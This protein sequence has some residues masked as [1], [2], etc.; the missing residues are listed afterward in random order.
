MY[1]TFSKCSTLFHLKFP[2]FPTGKSAEFPRRIT[3]VSRLRFHGP[4]FRNVAWQVLV[5][6]VNMVCLENMVL[7][8]GVK[9]AKPL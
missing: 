6:M 5:P 2:L 1:D 8:Y 4:F 3:T 7:M 9:K